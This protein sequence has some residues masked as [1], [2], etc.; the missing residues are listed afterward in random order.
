M[1]PACKV[2]KWLNEF[3]VGGASFLRAVRKEHKMLADLPEGIYVRAY[4]DRWE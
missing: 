3:S 4:E 1:L 2:H